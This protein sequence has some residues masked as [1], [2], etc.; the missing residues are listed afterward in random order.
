[1]TPLTETVR[2]RLQVARVKARGMDELLGRCVDALA[3][4]NG[5][6]SP[7]HGVPLHEMIRQYASLSAAEASAIKANLDQLERSLNG[8][9]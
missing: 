9:R 4:G 1:M 5:L 6:A 7:V 3:D 2:Q 8:L